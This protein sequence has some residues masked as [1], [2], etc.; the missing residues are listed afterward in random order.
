MQRAIEKTKNRDRGHMKYVNIEWNHQFQEIY[1]LEDIKFVSIRLDYERNLT[2]FRIKFHEPNMFNDI[3]VYAELDPFIADGFRCFLEKKNPSVF[4]IVL[5]RDDMAAKS[6]K[7]AQDQ[8][9]S[10]N[11]AM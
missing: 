3:E 2:E 4:L 10:K 5:K 11:E 8:P 7:S 9:Q 1:C 6:N